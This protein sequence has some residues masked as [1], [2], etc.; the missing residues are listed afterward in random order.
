MTEAATG[1]PVGSAV[2]PPR[3]RV[4][5]FLLVAGVAL[6]LASVLVLLAGPALYR[7]HVLALEPATAGIERIAKY[8][9]IAGGVVVAA[10]LVASAFARSSRGVITG[11][12][13]LTAALFIGFNIY[14]DE[15]LRAS[16]PPIHDVQTDW[17]RPVAFSVVTLQS[18]EDAGAA[19]IRDDGVLPPTSGH[20]AGKTF[21][22]AQAGAYDLKPLLVGV[23]PAKATVAVEVAA[24]RLGWN[25]M[26][27]SPPDGELEAVHYSRW[28][29]LASDIAV[30]VTPQGEG[31]RI[32]VRSTS[33][34]PGPDMGANAQRVTTLLNDVAQSLRGQ[35]APMV[36]P[37]DDKKPQDIQSDAPM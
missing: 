5:L 18:R 24:K 8:V 25:V 31:S 37:G 7:V 19:P 11:I 15:S 33:R 17:S 9:A 30:R 34:N 12:A 3:G 4:R 27:S 32:D 21:A 20:W 14:A 6:T 2:A 35:G 23:P 28:Y 26:R 29:G 36:Q 10:G 1:A 16:L 22:E 13:G